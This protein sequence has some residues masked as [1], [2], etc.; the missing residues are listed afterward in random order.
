MELHG[1]VTQSEFVWK[2]EFKSGF[3]SEKAQV[4]VGMQGLQGEDGR[5]GYKG[6]GKGA[7]HTRSHLAMLASLFRAL[8]S[9]NLAHLQV[10]GSEC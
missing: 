1:A 3:K 2:S 5:M 9:S 4:A 6:Q 7:A 8:P 10:Y